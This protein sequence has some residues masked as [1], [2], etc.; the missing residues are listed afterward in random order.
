VSVNNEGIAKT[1]D[2][3]RV[4]RAGGR[5]WRVTIVRGGQRISAV[6]TG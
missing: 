6:F 5:F 1:R 4:A 3:D 2:L